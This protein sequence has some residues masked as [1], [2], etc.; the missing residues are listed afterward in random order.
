MSVVDRF[1]EHSRI[2]Y[3]RNGGDDEV[4]LASADWMPRNL[5]RRIELLFPVGRG[6]PKVMG[7]LDAMFL[8]NV[9]SRRLMS[10]GSYERKRPNKGE[11]P[12]RAQVHLYRQA[13]AALERARAATGVTFEPVTPPEVKADV[14]SPT[15]APAPRSAGR[16]MT[17]Y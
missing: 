4:Y 11:E 12:F 1:L 9:K 13:A 10:D 2:F 14:L 15:S 5:D 6:A 7:I 3:F 16:R 8:D 17:K